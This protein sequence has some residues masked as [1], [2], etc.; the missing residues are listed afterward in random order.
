MKKLLLVRSRL[1]LNRQSDLFEYADKQAKSMIE[2]IHNLL[3]GQE[4]FLFFING[5]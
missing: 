4:I 3:A 2:Q 5:Q 1:T